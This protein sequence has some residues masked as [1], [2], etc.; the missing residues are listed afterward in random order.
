MLFRSDKQP[1]FVNGHRVTDAETI[2]IVEMVLSGTI[3]KEIVGFIN[4]N[5]GNAVGISGKDGNLIISK[6]LSKKSGILSEE[7]KK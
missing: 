5:G 1:K 7:L 4:I 3:N 2:K 6:K